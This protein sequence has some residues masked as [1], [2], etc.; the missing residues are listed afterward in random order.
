MRFIDEPRSECPGKQHVSGHVPGP[1]FAQC[2]CEREQHGTR[3]KR[4]NGVR[5]T[6][7]VT[8]GVYDKRFRSQ[9][10]L[11]VFEQEGTLFSSCNQTRCRRV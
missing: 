1:R 6:H 11:D 4:N 5:V 10:L 2:A 3:S 8:A 7:G 9:H